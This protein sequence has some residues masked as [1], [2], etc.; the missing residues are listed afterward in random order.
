MTKKS[1]NFLSVAMLTA[2]A[3]EATTSEA[4]INTE[5]SSKSASEPLVMTFKKDPS[6]FRESPQL[7]EFS[8]QIV[9]RM[10]LAMR[11]TDPSGCS[12]DPE[13]LEAICGT[14]TFSD[15]GAGGISVDDSD[16]AC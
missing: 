8:K 13:C 4:A 7:S 11:K 2:A 10:Y 3:L 6:E 5:H 1:T 15:N 16:S 9:N 14:G 12:G